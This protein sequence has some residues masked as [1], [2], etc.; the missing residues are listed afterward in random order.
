MSNL[1]LNFSSEFPLRWL[2]TIA[3][4]YTSYTNVYLQL[5]FSSRIRN[6]QDLKSKYKLKL[7]ILTRGSL[8]LYNTAGVQFFQQQILFVQIYTV[9]LYSIRFNN[10][11]SQQMKATLHDIK[12]SIRLV[13]PASPCLPSI[14][15]ESN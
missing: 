10:M 5:Y 13:L 6:G 7:T 9:F 12:P 4:L 14:C 8:S 15:R 1:G 2:S 3:S 11:K